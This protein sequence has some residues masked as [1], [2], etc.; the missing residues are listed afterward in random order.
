[1]KLSVSACARAICSATGEALA[2][3]TG[4]L[5]GTLLGPMLASVLPFGSGLAVTLL[6][7]LA[8]Y[9]VNEATAAATSKIDPPARQ[10]I[11]H[12]LQGAFRDALR[13]ALYD[14]GGERCFPQAWRGGRD[15]P[16]ET[17]FFQAPAMD[18][19]WRQGDPLA[20]QIRDCF[21]GLVSA[22]DAGQ[23]LP[24]DPDVQHA[25][26]DVR[27]YLDTETPGELAGAFYE[28]VTL[29]GL[30]RQELLL[31]EVPELAAHLRRHL[32]DRTL[33][34]LGEALKQRPAAWRA[35]N[36]MMLENLRGQVR[37]LG[38]GQEEILARLDA[39]LARPEAEGMAGWADGMADLLT[40]TGQ[41][42]KQLD[43]GFESVT[44]RVVA[45][46]QEV[47]TRLD[48]LLVV[49]VRIE[50]KVDRVLRILEDGHYIIE[51]KA[52]VPTDLP[53]EPGEPPYKG[54]QYFDQNDA[55][56]FFGR[57]LL[58]A[59]L[60]GHLRQHNFLA[61]VVGASGSGKSSV[62]RAGLMPA[63][64]RG[65]TLADGTLPPA[66]SAAW[67]IH[68]LT[69]T[70]HPLEALAASL[71]RDTESVTA[72]ATLA[73]DLKADPRSLGLYVRRLLASPRAAGVGRLL[74]VVDQFEELFTLC[75]DPDERKAFVDCLL[76][77]VGCD[78]LA[79]LAGSGPALNVALRPDCPTTVVIT[80]R[81][82]FYHHCGQYASLREALE[83][84]QAYIGPMGQDEL[85]RA[86]EEPAR[87]GRWE[88]E[89]GLVD[90]ML[91]DVGDEP[92]ALP[93]LS[94]AL[95]ETWKR[96][97]GRVMTLESYAES[98][99]V[100][101]AIAKTADAVY[102]GLAPEAQGIARSIFL[103]LTEL[104][105]GTQ[106]TRRRVELAELI[107]APEQAPAVQAVLKTLTDAR[108]V[109]TDKDVTSGVQTAEVAHEA[110]IREWPR[111]RGWLVEDRAGLRVHR[112]LTEAAL[113]WQKL[114]REPGSLYRGARLAEASE[115]AEGHAEVLN[116]LEREF[117]ATS[118]AAV[119]AEAAE[120][121]A[122]RQRE[123]A[124]AR[125]LAEEQK[126]RA[127][128]EK[129]RADI[130]RERAEEQTRAA[131]RL[132]QR[133][134]LLAGA[135]LVAAAFLVV[136]II[137]NARA[138][139]ESEHTL[140]RQ[141]AA[142]A[143][144]HVTDLDLALLLSLEADRLSDA[145][146]VR[147]SLLSA[148]NSSPRLLTFLHG[149]TGWVWNVA[150]SPD[151]R[152][153]ASASDD[154]T[155]ILWDATKHEQVGQLVADGNHTPVV[156]VAFSPDGRT[157]ASGS[158]DGQIILWDMIARQ[159]RGQPLTSHT[160][161]VWSLA[162]SPDGRL[163]A[164]GGRDR[165]LLLWDTA[166]GQVT[167]LIG[168]GGQAVV[169]S[170]VFSPDGRLLAAAAENGTIALWD[171][172]TGQR[173]GQPLRGYTAG[174]DNGAVA[175]LAFSPDGSTLASGSWDGLILLWDVITG[176]PRDVTLHA[177]HRAPITGLAFSPDGQTLASSCVDTT[178]LLWD[179]VTGRAIGKP[180]TGHHGWV[181]GLAF[182]PD[183]RTL[184][185]ASADHTVI[186][187][188]ISQSPSQ[189]SLPGQTAQ[190]LHLAFSPDGKTLASSGLDKDIV[191]WDVATGL[192]YGQPFASYVKAAVMDDVN[193]IAFSRDGRRLASSGFSAIT[194]WDTATHQVIGAPLR[195]REWS[196]MTDVAF[197]PDGLQVAA[198][199]QDGSVT[200]W[201]LETATEPIAQPL[202]G[203]P[204]RIYSL[205][206]SS[207]GRTL[208]LGTMANTVDLWDIIT[209]QQLGALP[210]H[211]GEINAIA[212]SPDG[213]LLASAGQDGVILLWDVVAQ[214]IVGRFEGHSGY[215]NGL[216]F[217]PDG[218]TMASAGGDKTV[219]LWD[220]ATRRQRG[221]A[222]VGHTGP[223]VSVAFSP[224][225]QIL[226]SSGLDK[227]LILWDAN[228]GQPLGEPLIG[229]SDGLLRM[230]FSPD[231]QIL[232]T[233]S[234]DSTVVL[235]DVATRRPRG[236]PLRGH[237]GSVMVVAF[238][239]DGNLLASA[240]ADDKVILWDA[241]T[242]LAVGEPLTGH[243]NQVNGVVFTPDGQGLITGSLDGSAWVWD[244]STRRRIGSPLVSY[245]G[246]TKMVTSVVYSPDGKT[247]A[248][249]GADGA[250]ILWDPKTGKML[251]EPLELRPK[252]D[253]EDDQ[254]GV[255]SLAFKPDGKV[256]ASGSSK[257]SVI[258][259][260]VA[261]RR[262]FDR[263][264][265][266]SED[267]PYALAFS[268]D[269]SMLALAGCDHYSET[270]YYCDRGQ[271]RLWNLAEHKSAGAPLVGHVS[272]VADVLFSPDGQTLASSA[273]D[274]TTIL[275]DLAARQPRHPPLTVQNG[276]VF[277]LA[278]S[279]VSPLLAVAGDAA[280]IALWNTETHQ[281]IGH[282]LEGHT[283]PAVSVAFSPDG[284]MLASGSFDKTVRLWDVARQL[285]V[286]Q[287][288]LGHSAYV[289]SV[290]FSPDGQ[291]VAS[292][293]CGKATAE[294]YCSAG[295]IRLWD[296]KSGQ[297]KVPPLVGHSNGIR[298]IVF[299]PDGKILASASD[300]HTIL[301]W[302]LA[303]G[304]PLGAPLVGHD[305]DVYALAFSPDG[306]TLASGGRDATVMLWDVSS[307]QRRG[308]PLAG[309][310][311]T[312]TSVAFSPDGKTLASSS[313]DSTVRLWDVATGQPL[314]S[315]MGHTEWVAAVAFSRDG[316]TLASAGND[317]AIKLWDLSPASWRVRACE[318]AHRNLTPIEWKQYLPGQMYRKTCAQWPAGMDS[319]AAV[320]TG[321]ITP[322]SVTPAAT[323]AA[324]RFT[325][326]LLTSP[327]IDPG[328]MSTGEMLIFADFTGPD[329]RWS[330]GSD[331]TSHTY[332]QDGRYHVE[333]S[334][335]G[336]MQGSL[337]GTRLGNYI[338]EVDAT[339]EGG[340]PT[341]FYGVLLRLI[342]GDN[343]Y[344]FELD[345][346]GA[347]R[348]RKR[349]AGE[350]IELIPWTKSGT[351]KPGNATNAIK[352]ICNGGSFT[353]LVNDEELA[354][355]QDDAFVSGGIGLFAGKFGA[356]GVVHASFDNLKVQ[357]F[358]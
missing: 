127:E 161:R 54:L 70:A 320:R 43:E 85:R 317:G 226:A 290:A 209:G 305:L 350:R 222:L 20:Q 179:P 304:R 52:A 197:S 239:P 288:L 256:L 213:A 115:Y 64:R 211:E 191:L 132:R 89:R 319:A 106:D 27:C 321:K 22:L 93:L 218:R 334:S 109:T 250:I 9:A 10:R 184:A 116:P 329:E 340:P 258:L 266:G 253:Q 33:V 194:I 25:A 338:L 196:W 344:S 343:H 79:Q 167:S 61:V 162:F 40:A 318:I 77:A 257:G 34:H 148:L 112:A 160:D 176:Q 210:G 307:G 124:A 87:L 221:P 261:A 358:Q 220:V 131:R 50:T 186:L 310:N 74:L 122:Q 183:G 47:V 306:K 98:G 11:N 236:D 95:L 140:S 165:Q 283:R 99:G 180:L 225:G 230:A 71:T 259:W 270:T 102:L 92:G 81:A 255:L 341:S 58:T 292:A 110:L 215:V 147:G 271:I 128:A 313:A 189:R 293:S 311:D 233:T 263:I 262:Q 83:Q 356:D 114:G 327:Q 342:D 303:T 59:R 49:T 130:Q 46:H 135:L 355:L 157:L 19:L 325:A 224:D 142:Q 108:L 72:A 316:T 234:R 175:S 244:L 155:V 73:A 203:R 159:P 229:H 164:S 190:M 48:G 185:S 354:T 268:P 212:F 173:R 137:A 201:N 315:F 199:S 7:R 348:F 60:A 18:E 296:V 139:R 308:Q 298:R 121:E 242:G 284:R 76:N 265:T 90:L 16:A 134:V 100:R 63:L 278:F 8:K 352:I 347:Y 324:R 123:L 150:F 202:Q 330:V 177:E 163:L 223:A 103:R 88:F 65:E 120:R 86:I 328:D 56:L 249:G 332:F 232:A 97:R 314:V 117:L 23:L 182:S 14:L 26:A 335:D 29:P 349:L 216:A 254:E 323:E 118:Q 6:A 152:T 119:A 195:P 331:D 274:G 145:P 297:Q 78:A 80:L 241:R 187:W 301:L 4:E 267:A 277:D 170:I 51:G 68:V 57:E 156:S 5:I 237:T 149:H 146:D 231:G 219:V 158:D 84:S 3:N 337:I 205:A 285:P 214:T 107:P 280:A 206:L 207:D 126:Q 37:D 172:S 15:V 312:I 151:G 136:A 200:L 21:Q 143:T 351:I 133:A 13:E 75:T 104:G 235:W 238:S 204:A 125:Q 31:Q 129:G 333:S 144:N 245:Y 94:H 252:D 174:T 247:L 41:I 111:L 141:L 39:L 275:W 295:E 45:Q 62:V 217:S 101:G 178:I 105:E 299:S 166:S 276:D 248:T 208:A 198:G 240:G 260:D 38:S 227:Q 251:G 228:T 357:A 353:L 289:F 346:K 36:R 281:M 1:M 2:G 168:Q 322:A 309:H 91:R 269:G 287:P 264:E 192:P 67:P 326:T 55:D 246:H 302:N 169:R 153:L 282:P 171:M 300:D 286:G 181:N 336:R 193:G 44:Q 138:H 24:W 69:P 291:V 35:F 53:P 32:L 345:G 294:G 243:N 113:A 28:Q 42:Q 96:R 272:A 279:P 339:F 154:G 66:G 17:V 30:A 273:W 82:D 188:A 12:D